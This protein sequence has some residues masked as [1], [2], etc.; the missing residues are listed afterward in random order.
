MDFSVLAELL[1]LSVPNETRRVRFAAVA[2]CAR[3]SSGWDFIA[4]SSF[5]AWIGVKTQR[6]EAGSQQGQACAAMNCDKRMGKDQKC[7]LL[8]NNSVFVDISRQ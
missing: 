2:F 8:L 5:N 3:V 6:V 7:C 4:K 1:D